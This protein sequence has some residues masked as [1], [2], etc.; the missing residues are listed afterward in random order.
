MDT[1][2][3]TK[4][5][6]LIFITFFIWGSV[7][8]AG[9]I[10]GNGMPSF[11]VASLRCLISMIP[12]WLMSEKCFPIRI[13]REDMKYFFIIGF[14][15]YFVTIQSIQLGILLTGS[16]MASLINALTPVAVT[17]L[18]AL[19]LKE[20]ITPVKILC[21]ILA[22]AG[23]F[24]ITSGASTQ[25][26]LLG[27]LAVLTG[28][29]SF[30]TASVLMRKVTAKYPPVVVTTVSMTLSLIFNIPVAVASALTQPVHPNAA[31]IIALL[32]LGFVG[33]GLG[34]VT[35][36]RALSILPASTCSLF[37]PLQPLFS[38]LL[39]ALLLHE[40]FKPAFF[41]GLVLISLDVVLNTLETR[42]QAEGK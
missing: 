2:R 17:I 40:T 16:S 39:G 9:G 34:Q 30:G 12:L 38:A 28:V 33:S 3:Q 14:L 8:V 1:A 10:A 25:G 18:A 5:Y 20:R 32:Y 11:L 7:Y 6:G 27:V 13:E 35:W 29:I 22:L 4:A 42:R 15:G 26:E 24:V 31:G 37:Y 41:A 21:L 23:T 36:T 19:I